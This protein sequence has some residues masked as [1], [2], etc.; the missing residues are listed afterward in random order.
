MTASGGELRDSVLPISYG[1]TRVLVHHNFR[2]RSVITSEFPESLQS[3]IV[4]Q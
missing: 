1:I 4:G 2:L 3:G